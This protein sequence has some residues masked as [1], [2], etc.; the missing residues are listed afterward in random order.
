MLL[1]AKRVIV[2]GDDKQNTPEAVGVLEDDVARLARDHLGAFSFRHEFRPDTS[3]FDHA[4]RAFGS[5]ISLREH[6]RCVPEIIRFSNDLCYTDAPL[7]PLCQP[8]PHRLLPL[9]TMFV[10]TGTCQGDG[11]RIINQPEADAIVEAIRH[12]L[13]DEVYDGKTLGV[14]VLQGHAQAEVI[15]K[16]LAGLLEPNVR[17]ER[18]IRCGVPATFQGDER[19]VIFLSLVVA[20][21]HRFRALTGL[22]DQRRFN[23]A[24]SR[25]REQVWLF[26]SVQ[27]HDLSRGD[28]RWKILNFFA[29]AGLAA[30]EE[31]YEELE[32]L[33]REARRYPR[34]L[35]DQPAPFESWFEVDV[36]L[37]LLRRKYRVRPQY[38]VAG[39]RIDIVLEGLDNRLAIECDGDAWHGAEQWEQDMARQRQL[40]RA[41]LTFVRIRESEFYADR[42]RA[43]EH[44]L[45]SCEQLGIWPT[46]AHNG[47]LLNLTQ[48]NVQ[49]TTRDALADHG[50]VQE[51]QEFELESEI[52]PEAAFGP[53]SGYSDESKFPDPREGSPASVRTAVR[54][55]VE[56][57]CPLPRESVYR[58][59]VQGC[60][61]LQRVGKA[62][63]QALSRALGTMLR[64]EEIIQEDEL[65]AGNSDGLVIRL[66]G[67]SKVRERP[68]GK[69]DLLEIPPSEL[70]LVLSR[71]FSFSPDTSRRDEDLARTLLEHFGFSRLTEKRRR[72]V[73]KVLRAWRCRGEGLEQARTAG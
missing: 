42:P 1:L 13:G 64:S 61:G 44:V 27:A 33:E 58:L 52:G 26:N 17:E 35:G 55:I 62:V 34:H 72:Y 7:I 15:E 23:V 16:K 48:E 41:R 2:V 70:F 31:A 57:E 69:R 10:D 45:K 47:T 56:R 65:G 51:E 67:T 8:P 29:G 6:F 21:D 59:Y 53:F 43:V 9:R 63:R 50:D 60:P 73:T 24:M 22:D 46:D 39:Y 30:S 40:E 3:L 12:C 18:K 49:D 19:D 71:H 32:R 4:E 38:E 68:A 11:Q 37:E 66:A 20:P 14:I 36:A 28:L 5:L 25:A 54:Q